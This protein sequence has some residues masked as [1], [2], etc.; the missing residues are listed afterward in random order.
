MVSFD[1]LRKLNNSITHDSKLTRMSDK[2]K[3]T[4]LSPIRCE[5]KAGETYA[6]CQCGFSQKAPFCD[7]SHKGTGIGP[8]MFTVE[9]D[10]TAV[11]YTHLTLPTKA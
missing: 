4:T 8:K 9:E 7:G 2:V 5:L 1:H 6:Y 3:T 10:R 11:S